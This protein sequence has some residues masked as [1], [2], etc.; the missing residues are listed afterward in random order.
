MLGALVACGFICPLLALYITANDD[1]IAFLAAI[2]YNFSRLAPDLN[3][4]CIVDVVALLVLAFHDAASKVSDHG[5]AIKA[6]QCRIGNNANDA[7]CVK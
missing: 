7:G 2:N 4:Y 1:A 3:I 5:A 6:A